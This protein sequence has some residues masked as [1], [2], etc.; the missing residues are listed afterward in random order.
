MNW[1]EAWENV[2]WS[3]A[4]EIIGG[5]LTAMGIIVAVSPFYWILRDPQILFLI[6]YSTG[7]AVL[8]GRSIYAYVWRHQPHDRPAQLWVNRDL[9]EYEQSVKPRIKVGTDTLIYQP[10]P[11]IHNGLITLA[12]GGAL[13]DKPLTTPEWTPEHENGFSKPAWRRM[14]NSLI[15]NGW[16]YIASGRGEIILTSAGKAALRYY[17]R[18]PPITPSSD[19]RARA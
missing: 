16:V 11:D 10:P 2:K 6:M 3:P 7:G 9:S 12:K 8:V 15:K 17:K 13:E 18:L 5:T 4:A 14:R 19:P 1:R